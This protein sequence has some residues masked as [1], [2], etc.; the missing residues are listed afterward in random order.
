M[1]LWRA[2]VFVIVKSSSF[3]IHTVLVA[4]QH[5]VENGKIKE[6]SIIGDTACLPWYNIQNIW[7]TIKSI[8]THNT[9]IVIHN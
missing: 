4:E 7:H 2:D 5:N 3:V 1:N 6:K 8:A 9:K